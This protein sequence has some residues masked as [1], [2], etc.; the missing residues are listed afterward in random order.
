M[1]RAR[2]TARIIYLD[3]VRTMEIGLEQ[4]VAHYAISSMFSS[5]SDETELFCYNV[6]RISY[7]IYT[8]GRGRLAIGRVHISSAITGQQKNFSFAVLHFGDQ[9]ITAA[10]KCYEAADVE[11][12]KTFVEQAA[13]QV[14][15]ADFPAG[16]PPAR[17]LLR[18]RGLLPDLAVP[19]RTTPHR[20]T[21]PQHHAA[22][23]SRAR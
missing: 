2:E 12:F 15:R 10:V 8:S 3:K 23:T 9:N 11:S 17:C 22:G 13:A 14:L 1:S 4:V 18:P 16:H 19:R 5:F 20:S 21:H 7:D 6:R